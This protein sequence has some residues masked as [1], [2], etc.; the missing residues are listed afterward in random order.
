M[1]GKCPNRT[2]VFSCAPTKGESRQIPII[3]VMLVF[4]L[5]LARRVALQLV[6]FSPSFVIA[7]DVGLGL[8]KI[9]QPPEV[10]FWR[11]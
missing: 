9:R 4:I 6:I 1:F 5:V 8:A 11:A 10:R 7:T 3:A 2:V